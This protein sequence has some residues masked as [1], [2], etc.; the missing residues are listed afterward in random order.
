MIVIHKDLGSYYS[1]NIQKEEAAIGGGEMSQFFDN[2]L[3]QVEALLEIIAAARSRDWEG[4]LAAI[5]KN[6]V[7][8][9]PWPDQLCKTNA[10]TLGPD[11]SAE[12]G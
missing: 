9:F 12:S 1:E 3:E 10:S 6:K 8:P 4:C 2:Y 7:L 5:E 11:V